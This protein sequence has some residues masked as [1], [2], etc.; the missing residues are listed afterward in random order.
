[1]LLWTLT[2]VPRIVIAAQVD[3]SN[4]MRKALQSA[5]RAAKK[6]GDSFLGVDTL[7][8]A[9][10]EA[11]DVAAVLTEAG[12]RFRLHPAPSRTF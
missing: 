1:M 4:D 8:R 7:L 2:S 6:A 11:K 12:E 10:L 3:L 9:L 5:S